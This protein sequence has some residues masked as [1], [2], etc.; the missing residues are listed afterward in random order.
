MVQFIS[1][2]T[3]Q[4]ARFDQSKMFNGTQHHP[5][6]ALEQQGEQLFN[7]TYNCARCHHPNVGPYMSEDFANIGLDLNNND[8]GRMNVSN[9]SADEGKFKVPD[10]H[11][12]ALTAPYMHDGRFKKLSEVMN[13]YTN[14]I[15]GSKTLSPLLQSKFQFSS[16]EKID[17]VAF[18][19][20]LT[21]TS[22]LFNPRFV[23]P[24][25]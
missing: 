12:V 22:F 6:S 7:T 4:N 25:D 23:F 14:G 11:N 1:Q 5:L 16:N 10:L 2:I 8:K 20:T 18:L 19:N 21:D 9:S 17:L 3:T 15:V 13:H 24:R